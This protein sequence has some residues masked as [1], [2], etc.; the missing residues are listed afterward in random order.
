[1]SS[2]APGWRSVSLIT[3]GFTTI[4]L[5]TSNILLEI[6]WE[7]MDFFSNCESHGVYIGEI[8]KQ[9]TLEKVYRLC[10]PHYSLVSKMFTLLMPLMQTKHFL[11]P[12]FH[13]K[14]IQQV[15]HGVSAGDI[16]HT[17][18]SSV[19]VSPFTVLC[20]KLLH[21]TQHEITWGLIVAR[22]KKANY[23]LRSLLKQP[24]F[25]WLHCKQTT[26]CSSVVFQTKIISKI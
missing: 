10:Q 23:W 15:K 17:S 5:K 25:V 1:M 19:R 12:L 24:K 8:K 11:L 14:S 4:F 16:L 26:T 22:W 2:T 13:F 7:G 18:N 21:S 9:A 20:W 3:A 6:R